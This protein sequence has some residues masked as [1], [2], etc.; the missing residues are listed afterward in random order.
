MRWGWRHALAT[1]SLLATVPLSPPHRLSCH[2]TWAGP[3]VA[4][5]LEHHTV[6]SPLHRPDPIDPQ[7]THSDPSLKHKSWRSWRS[8]PNPS[9]DAK[10]HPYPKTAIV[11]ALAAL[12]VLARLSSLYSSSNSRALSASRSAIACS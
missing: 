1:T 3:S 11:A 9:P 6:S 10:N 5:A 7:P 2:R 12:A 4:G 8:W